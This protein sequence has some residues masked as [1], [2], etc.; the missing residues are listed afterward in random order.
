ML[1]GSQHKTLSFIRDYMGAHGYSPSLSDIAKGLGLKSRGVVHRNVH[2]LAEAGFI[3]LVPGR[4]RNIQLKNKHDQSS[5][6]LLG[7]IAAGQPIE[8]IEDKEQVDVSQELT[9]ENRYALKVKGESMIDAGILDGDIVIIRSQQNA[10]NGDI[11]VALIDQNEA[12][13]KRYM[14]IDNEHIQL[15][16]ENIEMEP[17]TYH[18]SRVA[19]QGV[20][21]GQFRTY[22]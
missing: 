16:P 21:V 5:V 7:Q 20:L 6:P 3:E 13:L 15:S 22:N 10:Q 11:V 14:R 2:A 12:T 19:I 8:A 17:M 4:Q 18:Q 9:G 1:T